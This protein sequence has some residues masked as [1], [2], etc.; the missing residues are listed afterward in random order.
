MLSSLTCYISR[1]YTNQGS[2]LAL[3]S[4]RKYIWQTES[5]RGH[6]LVPCLATAHP[7]TPDRSRQYK[8]NMSHTGCLAHKNVSTGNLPAM[9]GSCRIF[10]TLHLLPAAELLYMCTNGGPSEGLVLGETR[11]HIRCGLAIVLLLV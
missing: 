9:L 4:L 1:S 10:A 11:L 7:Q 5:V 2:Y 8:K 3:S 6:D